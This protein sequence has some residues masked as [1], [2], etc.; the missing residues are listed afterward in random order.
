MYNLT[1]KYKTT[2]KE[3]VQIIY[4]DIEEY[5]AYTLKKDYSPS[6]HTKIRQV[7]LQGSLW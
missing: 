6:T 5:I 7:L 4:K 2:Y 3:R 1:V